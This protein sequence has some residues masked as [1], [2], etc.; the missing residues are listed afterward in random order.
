MKEYLNQ[1]SSIENL[2]ENG[3]FFDDL[4]KAIKKG[5][6]YLV[7]DKMVTIPH[8]DRDTLS[9]ND[10]LDSAKRVNERIVFDNGQ[11]LLT[12][13]DDII[14]LYEYVSAKDML[15]DELEIGDK[16]LWADPDDDTRDLNRVWE[17]YAI[18]SEELVK[19]ATGEPTDKGYSEAEVNPSELVKKSSI[20]HVEVVD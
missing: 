9:Y 6:A 3:T 19:I 16:V 20:I 1:V 13:S 15:G 12:A 17:V 2:E 8:S 5:L 11:Y 4:V 14:T 18:Q 10:I 7:V